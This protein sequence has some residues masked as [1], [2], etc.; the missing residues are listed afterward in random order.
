MHLYLKTQH[1]QLHALAA[2]FPDSTPEHCC[3]DARCFPEPFERF[4]VEEKSSLAGNRSSTTWPSTP[5]P[6]HGTECGTGT[7]K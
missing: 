7:A 2:L 3:Q 1:G 4:G 5:Y 6:N